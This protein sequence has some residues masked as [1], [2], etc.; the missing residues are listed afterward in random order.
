MEITSNLGQEIIKR[1]AKYVVVDINIMDLNGVIVASTDNSRIGEIHGGALDVLKSEDELII[2]ERRLTDYPGTRHGVNLPIKH[3]NRLAGVVGVSG[4]PE[5]IY[6]F[7]GLIRTAV[8]IVIERIHIERQGYFKERQ[9]S[10]WLHQ[11]LH[12]SGFDKGGLEEEAEYSLHVNIHSDWK[13]IVLSGED[14]V[15]ND[16]EKIRSE[17]KSIRLNVLFTL[18]FTRNEIIIALPGTFNSMEDFV[19]TL[20]DLSRT[21]CRIGIGERGFGLKGIRNSYM[22]AKQALYFAGKEIRIS[23]SSDWKLERLIAAIDEEAYKS[24]SSEFEWLLEELDY[25]YLETI[26]TFFRMN[27]S[28]K[29]TADFLH[30]HRNTLLYRFDQ[31][32]H[33]IG[34]DPRTFHDACILRIVRNKQ[35]Y[36][37]IQYNYFKQ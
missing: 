13:V 1:V 21:N 34:L 36:A 33:K 4:K 7:T 6:K 19:R 14:L 28:I 10:Y 3:N 9:W 11:L 22:L 31:I 23:D 15:D 35:I 37:N 27:L 8:E 29:K 26:D 2:D 17:I 20:L 5:E 32:H 25:I 24:V 30:V 18:P 12:P 16:L